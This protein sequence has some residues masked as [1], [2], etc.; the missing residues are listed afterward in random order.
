MRTAVSSNIKLYYPITYAC[1]LLVYCIWREKKER[2]EKS[3]MF[4]VLKNFKKFCHMFFQLVLF[5]AYRSFTGYK[6]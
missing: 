6:I 4:K 1:Y 2:G 3:E 5:P